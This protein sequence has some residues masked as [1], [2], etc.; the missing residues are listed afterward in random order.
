MAT[1]KTG[2]KKPTR[3]EDRFTMGSVE[4]HN[5][6]LPNKGKKKTRRGK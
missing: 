2:T 5:V 3:G 4:M 6:K 1:K